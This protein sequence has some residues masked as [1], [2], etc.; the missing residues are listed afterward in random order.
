MGFDYTAFASIPGIED[1]RQTVESE[2]FWGPFEYNRAFIVPCFIDASGTRDTGGSPTTLIRAGM[3]M[4]QIR[5]SKLLVEWNPAGTDGS[6]EIYGPLLYSQQTQLQ[7]TDKDRWFGFCAVG[8]N[9]KA[10]KLL[11]PGASSAGIDGSA[12]EYEVVRQMAGRFNFDG[13][14]NVYKTSALYG[15][16][17]KVVAKTADYTL[18]VDD[19]GCIFTNTGETDL[20]TLTLPAV[21]N[22]RGL[23]YGVYVTNDAGISIASAAGDDIVCDNDAAAD[24]VTVSTTGKCIG[25][26]IEIL[27]V[28]GSAWY[29]ITHL[30][31]SDHVITIAT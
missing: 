4:G 11:V 9:V 8:G 19:T 23:R 25:T 1:V 15:G 31:A 29:T 18:T 30:A 3:L 13:L 6:E 26:F 2:I 5:S 24:S 14:Y 27:G 12:Y 10:A 16:W 21:A 17:R 22:N 28:G 7:G 20:L